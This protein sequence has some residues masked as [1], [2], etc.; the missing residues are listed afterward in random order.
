[1]FSSIG[2]GT[3]SDI[4]YPQKIGENYTKKISVSGEWL[5]SI[6]MMLENE[7]SVLLQLH[8][9]WNQKVLELSEVDRLKLEKGYHN[10]PTHSFRIRCKSILLKSEGKSAPQ[11][12]EMLEVTVP[13]V[14][15]WVKRYEENGIKGLETRP[16]QGRKPIMDCS[17]EEAVRKAIEEDRQSVSKAREAWQNATG[18]EAS[19]IT[20]K[21]FLETLVQDISV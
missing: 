8:I 14:Y 6:C 9:Q 5:S 7:D 19:D 20:F 13:T 10:G 2:V 18:K 3:F 12:A 1:M 4:S 11:I 15:T 17:D 16:G 21:R